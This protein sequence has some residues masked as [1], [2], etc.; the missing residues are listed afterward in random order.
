MPERE[1]VTK[2]L[3]RIFTQ[4]VNKQQFFE[5]LAAEHLE[6]YTRGKAIGF[7]DTVTDR[8]YR[9]KTLGLESQFTAMSKQIE[10]TQQPQIQEQ[11]QEFAKKEATLNK[12]SKKQK[13][14]V[15]PEKK[16]DKAKEQ[17]K[18]HRNS[19]KNADSDEKKHR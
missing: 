11:K 13:R 18:Q 9:L 10:L 3:E 17:L 1:R 5:R 16:Q 2:A 12:S 8:K 4:S 15:L 7:K 6:I 14:D 19:H